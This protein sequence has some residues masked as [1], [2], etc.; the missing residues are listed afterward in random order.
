M[1]IHFNN[2]SCNEFP[3]RCSKDVLNVQLK[4]TNCEVAFIEIVKFFGFLADFKGK[5]RVSTGFQR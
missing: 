5:L 1:G 3:V 4:I 2:M